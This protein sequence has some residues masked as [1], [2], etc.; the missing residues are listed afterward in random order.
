[1]SDTVTE[2]GIVCMVSHY[3]VLKCVSAVKWFSFCSYWE[4]NLIFWEV[5]LSRERETIN[6][7]V[8]QLGSIKVWD[9]SNAQAETVREPAVFQKTLSVSVV[10][11][12]FIFPIK[13]STAAAV[14][15]WLS[16]CR[17]AP[18]KPLRDAT[19]ATVSWRRRVHSLGRRGLRQRWWGYSGTPSDRSE[20]SEPYLLM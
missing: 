20:W 11:C 19:V 18:E 5:L 2:M 8:V 4:N 13:T 14:S 16:R 17:A 10:L 3:F 1:M 6:C 12:Q 7:I 9:E 15:P